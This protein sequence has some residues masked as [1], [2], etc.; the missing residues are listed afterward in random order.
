MGRVPTPNLGECPS[1]HNPQTSLL[2]R[3]RA[4]EGGDK[5]RLEA[6]DLCLF[7]NVGLSADFKTLEFDKYKESSFPRVHLAM[8]C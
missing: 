2:E 7:S 3:L 1:L 8:Y 5:Y 4:V 6:V